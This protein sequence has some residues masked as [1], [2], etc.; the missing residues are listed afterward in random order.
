[1]DSPRQR[2]Y[3][4]DWARPS[5]INNNNKLCKV[6]DPID[7]II[8]IF[9]NPK[10][11]CVRLCRQREVHLN[12]Y[13]PRAH[14]GYWTYLIA[15]RYLYNII[16]WATT[17]VSI[18]RIVGWARGG[19]VLLDYYYILQYACEKCRAKYYFWF[20]SVLPT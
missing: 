16:L 2:G 3:S 19:R 1:M 11:S 20:Y 15:E 18:C 6:V 12:Y 13:Y 14:S 10:M 7:P 17:A 4:R 5:H 8:C 9:Y